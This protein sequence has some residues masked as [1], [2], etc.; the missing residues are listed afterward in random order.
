MDALNL[1]AHPFK[2][3]EEAGVRK[4]FDPIRKKYLVLTPEE[5]VRQHFVQFLV[6][7]KKFPASLL[8][9]EKGLRLNAMQKRVDVLANDR[10]GRPFLI[11][12]CK[13]PTVKITQEV[14][15][16]IARYN[17][18]FKVPYLIVTNGLQHYCCR[19]DHEKKGYEFLEDIPFYEKM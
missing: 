12:E 7:S 1:P 11:V 2:L 13:A 6:Q 16:Q 18:V 15:D 3:T 4:I 19:I 10:E 5:W 17:L 14:F 9:I 8:E